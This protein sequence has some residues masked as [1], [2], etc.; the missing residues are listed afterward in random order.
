MEV[1]GGNSP[2]ERRFET[3]GLQVWLY[4]RPFQRAKHGGDVYYVSSC[5]SG[6]I[7]R[8]LLADVSGHGEQV[9]QLATGLRDL[10]RQNVNLIDQARF[11]RGMN[12]QFSAQAEGD[13]FATAVVCTFFAPTR[14]LQ[15]CNAGHPQPLLYRVSEGRWF[16]AHEVSSVEQGSGLIDVPLGIVEHADYSRFNTRLAEG[17]MVL[18]VSDAFTESRNA[19]GNLLGTSGL[20]RIVE[21]LDA[22]RPEE[23]LNSLLRRIATEYDTNLDQDDTTAV[24]FRADGSHVT[25]KNNLLAPFRLLG[26]VRDRSTALK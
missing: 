24:L 3:P 18:C 13:A 20:K 2:I 11:L 17:D 26:R 19:S 25:W 14:S 15:L 7:T 9:A 10:M 4:C 16:S 23:F 1:W 5:A 8:L 6:R 12:Q 22:K 21:S